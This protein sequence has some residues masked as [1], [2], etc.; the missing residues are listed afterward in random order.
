MEVERVEGVWWLV[1]RRGMVF[2]GGETIAVKFHVY[3]IACCSL[4]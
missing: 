2:E 4:D 1:V 3:M